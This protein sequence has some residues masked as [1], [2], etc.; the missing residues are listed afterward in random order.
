MSG[1]GCSSRSPKTLPPPSS[2]MRAAR[3][4]SS[5]LISTVSSRGHLPSTVRSRDD[6]APPIPETREPGHPRSR[7]SP[8]D[9]PGA[10]A[11]T[12]RHTSRIT[13]RVRSSPPASE[14][15]T[16]HRETVRHTTATTTAPPETPAA[17]LHYLMIYGEEPPV[18]SRDP[19][20]PPDGQTERA[21]RG[22]PGPAGWARQHSTGGN[23][24]G[25]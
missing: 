15:R 16:T 12:E 18:L 9:G 21:P 7:H 2:P 20:S 25:E 13:R 5:R 8:R 10:H 1:D 6:P 17:T 14:Q 24:R 4:V 3:G 22:T 11:T 23:R 19:P